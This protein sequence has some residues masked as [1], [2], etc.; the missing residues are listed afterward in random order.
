MAL[1]IFAQKIK[2]TITKYFPSPAWPWE[3]ITGLFI[4][5]ILINNFEIISKN[6][7]VN[8]AVY[9][10]LIII[11]INLIWGIVDSLGFIFSSLLDQGRYN[12][13]ISRVKS[14]G[15]ETA[16]E[17]I[18]K[19]LKYTIISRCD[20]ETK[21]QIIKAIFKNIF[22][23][24]LAVLKK[25]KVSKENIIG[26]FLCVFFVFLPC[27]LILPFFIAINDISLAILVSNIIG[28][29]IFFAF[30]YKLGSCAN[31]NKIL[32]GMIIMLIG[33]AIIATAI[34]FGA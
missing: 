31:R 21:G 23:N 33:L 8:N 19:E 7:A 25:P 9:F 30:G 27:I 28:L 22:S 18:A 17:A 2:K 1:P 10:A 32:T 12:K 24:S 34:A 5:L 11:L 20:E 3:I 26:A 14:S 15:R 13:V 4:V 16:I 6:W 29:A